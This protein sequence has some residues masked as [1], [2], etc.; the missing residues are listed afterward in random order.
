MWLHVKSTLKEHCTVKYP[1]ATD[2]RLDCRLCAFCLTGSLQVHNV[3]VSMFIVTLKYS[4]KILF[5]FTFQIVSEAKIWFSVIYEESNEHHLTAR[6]VL[7]QNTVTR[8]DQV[9]IFISAL[10]IHVLCSIQVFIS[11]Q[12]GN[13]KG[14]GSDFSLILLGYPEGEQNLTMHLYL[15]AREAARGQQALNPQT[16]SS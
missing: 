2:S 15:L 14:T 9:V 13:G 10:L 3:R 1:L 11:S 12:S 5:I 8:H 6:C 16:N 7:T 4:Q